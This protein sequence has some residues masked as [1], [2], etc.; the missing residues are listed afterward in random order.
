MTA[1]DGVALGIVLVFFL[2]GLKRG[3]VR[4]AISLVTWVVAFFLTS[5]LAGMLGPHLPGMTEGGLRDAVA[6]IL[7]FIAILIGA[8]L[9]SST[10]HGLVK[11]AGLS[12]EDRLLG[13]VFGFLRGGVVL[14]VLVLVTGLTVLPQTEIWKHSLLSA[15]LTALALNFKGMLP[16]ELADKIRFT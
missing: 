12:L 10:L 14:I 7:A 11:A 1:L 9:I 15:P 5:R 2:L 16:A 8:M 13:A 6:M 4:E 3:L